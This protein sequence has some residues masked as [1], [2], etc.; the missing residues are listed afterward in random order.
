MGNAGGAELN[1]KNA[2]KLA[3]TWY[4]IDKKWFSDWAKITGF[5]KSDMVFLIFTNFYFKTLL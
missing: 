5:D 2:N 4:A 1:D 3:D